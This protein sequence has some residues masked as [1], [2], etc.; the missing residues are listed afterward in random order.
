[1]YYGVVNWEKSYLIIEGKDV[2]EMFET[3]EA[4]AVFSCYNDAMDY[5]NFLLNGEIK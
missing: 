5:A 3:D 2:I 1:M 4:I